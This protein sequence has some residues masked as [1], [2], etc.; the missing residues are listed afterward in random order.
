MATKTLLGEEYAFEPGFGQNKSRYLANLGIETYLVVS[1][2][3]NDEAVGKSF[4][5]DLTQPDVEPQEGKR[6]KFQL[7][8]TG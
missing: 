7:G 8:R 6:I 1:S 2:Y 4:D 3:L 5:D